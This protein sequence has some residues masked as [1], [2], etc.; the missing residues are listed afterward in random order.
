[1]A[2]ISPTPL[3]IKEEREWGRKWSEKRIGIRGDCGG[4]GGKEERGG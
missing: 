2:L 1:V 4:R 3:P